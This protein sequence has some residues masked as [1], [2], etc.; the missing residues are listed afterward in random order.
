V[1]PASPQLP[2]DRGNGPDQRWPGIQFVKG[3]RQEAQLAQLGPALEFFGQ[4]VR[5]VHQAV[6]QVLRQLAVPGQLSGR[7][8]NMVEVV[9]TTGW[10]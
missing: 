4:P 5:L 1:S 3:T 2:G 8:L 9:M 6:L 7:L 10:R